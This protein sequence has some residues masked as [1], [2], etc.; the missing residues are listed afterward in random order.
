MIK[1]INLT[2]ECCT[3][4]YEGYFPYM[5]YNVVYQKHVIVIYLYIGKQQ[6]SKCKLILITNFSVKIALYYE[7][8]VF[9]VN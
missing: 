3:F 2:I 7:G 9:C 1:C 6:S 5:F 4:L 8:Q